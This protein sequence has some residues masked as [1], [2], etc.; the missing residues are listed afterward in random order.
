VNALEFIRRYFIERGASPSLQEIAE[1]IGTTAQ[2]AS[3]IVQKLEQSGDIRPARASPR[4]AGHP[5]RTDRAGFE[6]LIFRRL[7]EP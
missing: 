7:M 5:R 1:A 3:L 2:G 6:Y 4:A